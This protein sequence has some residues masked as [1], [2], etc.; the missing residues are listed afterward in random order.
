MMHKPLVTLDI[1]QRET[2]TL[3]IKNGDHGDDTDAEPTDQVFNI[4]DDYNDHF[5]VDK[6]LSSHADHIDT[7]RNDAGHNGDENNDY[8]DM[9]HVDI[10][11]DTDADH[12]AGYVK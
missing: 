9:K 12:N 11:D 10:D 8:V 6:T 5:S 4:Q 3:V 2:N 7:Y 1:S